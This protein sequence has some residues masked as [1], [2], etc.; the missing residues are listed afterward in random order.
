MQKY[1]KNLK[2]IWQQLRNRSIT[3]QHRLMLYF[4]SIVSVILGILLFALAIMGIFSFSEQQLGQSLSMG[5]DRSVRQITEQIDYINA[6]GIKLSNQVSTELSYLLQKNDL[7]FQDLN[8]NPACIEELQ[9]AAYN[10]LNTTLELCGCSGAY[11]IL[12]ITTNS[13]LSNAAESRSGLYLRR[14]SVNDCNPVSSETAL[15]RGIK[16][17]ARKNKLELHNRW[18]MEFDTKKLPF[19]Q[20][21]QRNPPS[22][23]ADSY[24]WTKKIPLTGTWEEVAYLVVPIV[25]NQGEFYGVCGIELSSLYFRLAYPSADSKFGTLVTVLAPYK[26]NIL[27]LSQGLC[28]A[29]RGGKFTEVPLHS[30][31]TRQLQIYTAEECRYFGLHQEIAISASQMDD[32]QWAVAV[33]MPDTNYQSYTAQRRLTVFTLF[34]ILLLILIVVSAFLSRRY[35][36]PITQRIQ[37][38]QSGNINC[39]TSTGLSELDELLQFLQ[40]QKQNISMDKNELPEGIQEMF[41][42]FIERTKNLTDAER[43]ILGYYINGYQIAEIP[44]LAYISMSTVRKH[45]RSIYEKLEVSSRDELMLY[46]DLLRRCGRIDDI[47]FHQTT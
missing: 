6:Q 39:D 36:Q 43:N 31:P 15:F 17:V 12:D 4:L 19:Y 1:F 47:T 35:V 26:E 9:Q 44:E 10:P 25:G 29:E 40:T 5:L 30:N 11:I 24:F 21:L 22:R 28:G 32:V 37:A 45:N 18:N 2:I 42:N 20:E 34:M 41:D 38:I 13:S 27:H 7:S 16:E 23:A 8:D 33:L 46:I 14:T 3:M